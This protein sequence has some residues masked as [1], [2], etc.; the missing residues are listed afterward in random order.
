[1][2]AVNG[3]LVHMV[4]TAQHKTSFVFQSAML[5]PD[6]ALLVLLASGRVSL[7]TNELQPLFTCTRLH[8]FVS[9]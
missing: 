1:M 8:L 6:L 2:I 9:F 3:T 4:L 7:L 5:L